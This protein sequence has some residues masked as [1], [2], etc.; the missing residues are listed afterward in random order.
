MREQAFSI[1]ALI[2]EYN[3]AEDLS[4]SA[5]KNCAWLYA[6]LEQAMFERD[7]AASAVL[8][9]L[10]PI[11]NEAQLRQVDATTLEQSE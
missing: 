8:R 10:R 4:P 5:R 1:A 6:Q 2:A 9:L 11:L 7:E 3:K